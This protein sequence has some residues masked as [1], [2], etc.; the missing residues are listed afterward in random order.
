MRL[1]KPE[2]HFQGFPR[3]QQAYHDPLHW[4][5]TLCE[6]WG[7]AKVSEN[8]D[9]T[10]FCRRKSFFKAKSRILFDVFFQPYRRRTQFAYICRRNELS[11]MLLT[12]SWNCSSSIHNGYENINR[13]NF[14]F[15]TNTPF[16][17]E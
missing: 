14:S 17:H 15:H 11:K 10:N 5:K 12:V 6:I 2:Q 1:V 7:T 9:C 4:G 3:S 16:L 8:S 13:C